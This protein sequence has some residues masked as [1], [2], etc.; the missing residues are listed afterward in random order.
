[1]TEGAS[2]RGHLTRVIGSS[3]PRTAATAFVV[4][5][6]PARSTQPESGEYVVSRRHDSMPG[7]PFT[8]MLD[9]STVGITRPLV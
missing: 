8:R 1:M 9:C 5:G 4:L 6:R 2:P 3:L 7:R